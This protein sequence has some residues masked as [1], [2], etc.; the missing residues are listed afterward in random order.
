MLKRLALLLI[1]LAAFCGP[2][3]AQQLTEEEDL[4][5]WCGSAF[6]WLGANASDAGDSKE[7][8]LYQAWSDTL[9]ARGV[10]LLKADQLNADQ[11]A[12]VVDTYDNSVVAE[13][14]TPKARHDVTKCP[15][16]LQDAK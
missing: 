13:L 8:D 5:L 6:F 11:I 12:H 15:D 10:A 3:A 1:T 4:I 14:G 9:M 2:A 7:A 16:L